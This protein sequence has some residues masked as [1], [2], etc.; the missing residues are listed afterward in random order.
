[1][2]RHKRGKCCYK[3]QI[4]PFSPI[5]SNV[6]PPKY[7]LNDLGRVGILGDQRFLSLIINDE[8]FVETSGYSSI[9]LIAEFSSTRKNFVIYKVI[10]G[11]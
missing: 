1:M 11:C 9:N 5:T 3:P 4:S 7:G 6:T 2:A 10:A 8:G